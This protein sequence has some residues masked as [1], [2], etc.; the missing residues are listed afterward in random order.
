[1]RSHASWREMEND[2][3]ITSVTLLTKQLRRLQS[4]A[5]CISLN[6]RNVLNIA[7][8]RSGDTLYSVQNWKWFCIDLLCDSVCQLC[9][10]TILWFETA[11]KNG[12]HMFPSGCLHSESSSSRTCL[13]NSVQYRR[14]FLNSVQYG[15]LLNVFLQCKL[16]GAMFWEY[17]KK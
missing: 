12:C 16:N 2:V 9:I 4:G 15:N 7:K 1:M 13:L 14:T 6:A 5:I 10:C 3:N 17:N 11:K 8:N